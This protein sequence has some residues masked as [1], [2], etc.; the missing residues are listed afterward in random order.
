ML[1]KGNIYRFL[2]I[3]II[4]LLATLEIADIVILEIT[5]K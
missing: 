3:L 1:K 4:C 2:L 5:R